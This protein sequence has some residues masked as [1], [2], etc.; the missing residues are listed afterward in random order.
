MKLTCE[1]QLLQGAI[2]TAQRCASNRSS[3]PVLGGILISAGPGGLTLKATDLEMAVECVI[4]AQVMEEG[5]VVAPARYLSDL[6][7]RLPDQ[8]IGIELDRQT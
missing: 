2:Q 1:K 7:R 4:P 5:N 8:T 3:I 6:V